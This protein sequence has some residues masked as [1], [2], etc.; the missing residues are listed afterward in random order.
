MVD[1]ALGCPAHTWMESWGNHDS[2]SSMKFRTIVFV[3]TLMLT[4]G[5]VAAS[6]M[7][8]PSAA[9]PPIDTTA[10]TV[11]T[12]NGPWRFHVGDDARWADPAF[13]DSRW[14]TYAIDPV[15]AQLTVPEALEAAPMSGWQGHGHPGYVGYAWYRISIDAA[16]DRSALAILMPQHVDDSYQVYAN[17]KQIGAFGQFEAHHFV[18]YSRPELF[19]V[20]A[21]VIPAKGPLTIALRFHS[22]KFDALPNSKINGGLRGL[23]LLGPTPLLAVC[24]QAQI[25]QI[26][27]QIWAG[28]AFAFL[29]GSVG[30]ISLFLFLFTRTRREYL[31]A[32]IVLTGVAIVMACDLAGRLT[33][34]PI[35]I[36]FPCRYVGIWIGLSA[37]PIFVMYLLGVHKPLWRRL[38]YIL[39]AVLTTGIAI[40]LSI[41]VGLAPPTT[42]WEGA[43]AVLRFAVLGNALLVLAI[44]I[45]GVRTLGSK[46]WLPLT[47]GLF[48]ACGLVLELAGRQF[49][50]IFSGLMLLVPVALLIVFLLRAAQQHRENEQYLL[51]MRQAQEIQQLLLPENLPIVAGFS[52]ESVY[53][54]ARE[55][56]GDFFQVLE[57]QTGSILI[58][59]GDVAGKGLPA[60]MLV[61]MLV[62][63]IR[64]RAQ[65][66]GDPAKILDALN[67]RL[68]G[69]TRGGFAT[70]IAVHISSA[71]AVYMANA[72]HL[73]PYLNGKEIGL[74]GALPLGVTAEIEFVAA[75]FS[76][77]PGDRLTIVSDGVVEATNGQ[78]ELF[79]FDR[80]R[81]ISTQDAQQIADAA[82]KFGQEDDITVLTLQRLPAPA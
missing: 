81:E 19:P 80:L 10:Q 61:A 47:P 34:I 66:T 33:P 15:H 26:I 54:P 3:V 18:Y 70:C 62:G 76:L 58:V 11:A 71:G 48:G 16:Y 73:V 56:G 78:R 2:G 30:L 46:A 43:T 5:C 50:A 8:G 65:E 67:D 45:D 4:L 28:G 17:G 12:E 64:T 32:G 44:A 23:P 29:W 27:S 21:G 74:D 24:Y 68:C 6:S 7:Q 60:A 38:N 9:E 75:S 59:F 25:G 14:E 39:I 36:M 22:S 82:K 77:Q 20:P 51:D 57:P 37:G 79:G 72:G 42:N 31:W 53:L 69:N 55:V 1:A 63:A 40:E 49:S 13:D 35:Q 41:Y 52:I